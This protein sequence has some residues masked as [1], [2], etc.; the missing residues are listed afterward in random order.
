LIFSLLILISFL[1]LFHAIFIIA[2]TPTA[3]HCWFSLAIFRH[4]AIAIFFHFHYAFAFIDATL[5]L[6]MPVFRWLAFRFSAFVA[7]GH[8]SL[9]FRFAFSHYSMLSS[10]F[11]YFRLSLIL[12]YF[13]YFILHFAD[14]IFSSRHWFWHDISAGIHFRHA[15]FF[16]FH[17]HSF[18][19]RLIFRLRHYFI[20]FHYA[21]HYAT[22]SLLIIIILFSFHFRHWW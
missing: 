3:F 15:I 2:I 21:F 13:H 6:L 14:I 16:H 12:H 9:I 17:F 1:S 18:H 20:D 11:R 7:F 19:A 8:Y 22:L 10:I 5:I 4:Y